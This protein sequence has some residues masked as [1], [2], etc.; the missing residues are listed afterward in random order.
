MA[1]VHVLDHP[2]IQHKL[3]ILRNK[4]TGSLH[5]VMICEQCRR[6]YEGEYCDGLKRAA[7]ENDV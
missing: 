1:N 5:C 2:L 7:D 3:A 6:F 4:E